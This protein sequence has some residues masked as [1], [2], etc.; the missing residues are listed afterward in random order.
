MAATALPDPLKIVPFPP[1][2]KGAG[3]E[4]PVMIGYAS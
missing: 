2:V 3:C 1:N 4:G